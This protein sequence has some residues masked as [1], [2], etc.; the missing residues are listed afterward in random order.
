MCAEVAVEVRHDGIVLGNILL[1]GLAAVRGDAAHHV[2][3]RH[4]RSHVPV[5]SRPCGTWRQHTL[6]WVRYA[7][8]L[9]ARRPILAF[10]EG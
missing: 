7:V 10:W 1:D 5:R 4:T 8:V 3:P 2:A 6:C 9:V